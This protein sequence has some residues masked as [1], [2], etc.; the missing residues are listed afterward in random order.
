MAL[1]GKI[2]DM[3]SRTHFFLNSFFSNPVLL[4][5]IFSWFF[6]QFIKTVIHLLT[7]KVKSFR[8]VIEL[9]VWHTGGMPS[10]HS[11]LVTS[12]STSIGI[13]NGL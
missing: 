7:R 1:V 4:A 3:F 11:A 2:V 5:G 8:D 13:R 10:S 9:L 12:L 6:A